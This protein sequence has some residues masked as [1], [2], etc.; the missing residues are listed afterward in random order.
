MPIF[1][2]LA[3]IRSIPSVL[4][5]AWIAIGATPPARANVI[6]DWDAKAVAFAAPGAQGER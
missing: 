4:I 3:I 5:G 1:R 2:A 6:T